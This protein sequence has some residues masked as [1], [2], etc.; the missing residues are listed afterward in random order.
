MIVQ[1]N[2]RVCMAA[3]NPVIT[4][5]QQSLLRR[6]TGKFRPHKQNNLSS[7]TISKKDVQR[8]ITA[9]NKLGRSG[10]RDATIIMMAY[11]H[12]LKVSEIT[13]LKWSHIDL[14]KGT[15]LVSRLKNGRKT[16][17]P[18]TDLEIDGLRKLEDKNSNLEFVFVTDRQL[19]L[20]GSHVRHLVR[21][22]GKE[23]GLR[24]EIDPEMLS[25]ACKYNFIYNRQMI[26]STQ[27]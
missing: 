5:D 24:L 10:L 16:I 3:I 14:D 2:R 20:T 7:E 1:T 19:P 26:P 9:A 12:G 4:I 6:F 22:A 25:S 17:H 11:A 13:N 21:R 15:L 27:H 23:A 8:L 18:L